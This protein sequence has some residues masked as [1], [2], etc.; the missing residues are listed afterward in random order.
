MKPRASFFADLHDFAK[1]IKEVKVCG[2]AAFLS[3]S[4]AVSKY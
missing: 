3:L 2:Y 1:D 4:D